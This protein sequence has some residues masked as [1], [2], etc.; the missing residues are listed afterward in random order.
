MNVNNGAEDGI[1][2]KSKVLISEANLKVRCL[3]PRF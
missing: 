3:H 2:E 1:G